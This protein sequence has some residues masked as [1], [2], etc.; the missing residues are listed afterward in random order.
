MADHTRELAA[1]AKELQV[2]QAE[3]D[4]LRS[5]V[6]SE[7]SKMEVRLAEERNAK[8]AAKAQLERRI[9]AAAAKNSKFKVRDLSVPGVLQPSLTRSSV[10]DWSM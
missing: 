8:E 2:V 9:D 7:R 6:E 10:S 4:K 5:E 3:L 1:K